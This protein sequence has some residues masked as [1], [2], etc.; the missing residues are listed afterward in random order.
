M[1]SSNSSRVLNFRPYTALG[2]TSLTP[3]ESVVSCFNFCF[4]WFSVDYRSNM[5]SYDNFS[6][7]IIVAD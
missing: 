3:E 6:L 7:P 1:R 2:G 4:S 5:I